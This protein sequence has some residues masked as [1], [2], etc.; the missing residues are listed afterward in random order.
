ARLHVFFD[1][2]TKLK[3][4]HAWSITAKGSEYEL[5]DKDFQEISLDGGGVLYNDVKAKE[6]EVP[7]G[8]PGTVVAIEVEQ[9]Q[10]PYLMG[11]TWEFQERIPVQQARYTLHLPSSWEYSSAW[12]AHEETKPVES[13]GNT[14]SWQLERIPG[15]EHEPRMPSWRAIAGRMEVSYFGNV[16]GQM[17]KSAR[18][19]QQIGS[20]YSQLTAGRRQ[21]SPEIHAKALQLTSGQATFAGKVSAIAAFLQTDIRYVAIEIGIGGYQPH[22]AADVFRYRYGDCKDKATLMSSMLHEA[23]IESSYLVV[24]TSRGEVV[25]GVPSNHFD[26]VIL[27]IAV[28]KGDPAEKLGTVVDTK[29]GKYLIFDPTD[30]LTPVGQLHYELQGS[31][32]LLVGD[33]TGE[34]IELPVLAPRENQIER[35]AHLKLQSDGSLVGDVKE[36]RTGEHAWVSR[37][38]LLH[39]HGN[40]RER[41]LERFLSGFL[42]GFSLQKSES[43]NLESNAQDLILKYQFSARNYAKNAGPLLLVRPR[44]LGTKEL[45]WEGDKPRKFPIVFPAA[46]HESDIFEIE[47]PQGF[48]VD[49]LPDPVKIDVGFAEYESKTEVQ[50]QILRYTRDYTLRKLEVPTTQETELRKLYSAIYSDERNSAVLKPK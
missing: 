19:W 7:G 1:N 22:P 40:E 17:A 21:A 23:G 20:W 50:G 27:A 18:S 29:A 5:K 47:L 6:A 34:L 28:P 48:A 14:W 41:A 33:N 43:E 35:V 44:V 42:T 37:A 30:E 8:D 16:R 15:I 13:P 36:T 24:N 12:F 9:R 11:D 38:E 31:Y 32:G 45:R 4:L 25:P 39:T 10:R 2:E 49:E 3:S 46:S 26:H